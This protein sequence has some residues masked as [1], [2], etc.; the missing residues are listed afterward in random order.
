MS[1][2]ESGKSKE[3]LNEADLSREIEDKC[4]KAFVAF[5]PDGNGG[6]V[7]SDQIK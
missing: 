3:A 7:K 4:Y 2:S 1:D 5:D 6:Q